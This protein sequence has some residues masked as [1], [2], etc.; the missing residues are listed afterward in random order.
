MKVPGGEHLQY[1]GKSATITINNCTVDVDSG[2]GIGAPVF[3]SIAEAIDKIK[4]GDTVYVLPNG[5][6]TMGWRNMLAHTNMRFNSMTDRKLWNRMGATTTKDK[7]QAFAFVAE[8]RGKI[9]LA[10]AARGKLEE[11]HGIR[12]VQSKERAKVLNMPE[13]ERLLRRMDI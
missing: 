8:E 7:L 12:M 4:Q 5:G 13:G 10:A 3:N 9:G 6:D 11:L 1:E 2:W